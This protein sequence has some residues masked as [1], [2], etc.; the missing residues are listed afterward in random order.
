VNDPL[1]VFAA[2]WADE[3]VPVVV[4]TATPDGRP[5]AR[6]VVLEEHGER[7]FV[8][9]TSSESRKGRELAANARAA[10][11][12]VWSGRQLRVEGPVEPVSDAENEAHWAGRE[13][14][15]QIAAF[16][17]D[18]PVGS[19]AELEA[20]VAAMPEEPPRPGFW[21]G[22]RVAP[23]AIETWEARDDFVHDRFRY[24]PSDGG[25]W[26]QTRLQP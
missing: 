13:A 8:F 25:G 26:T 6:A 12:F 17:Q 24:A 22:Y 1:A 2:W 7:G 23:E 3:R 11:V 19:R 9:W 21:V 4:A 10:L 14:R 15:R 18:D 20:L 16:R 5:S